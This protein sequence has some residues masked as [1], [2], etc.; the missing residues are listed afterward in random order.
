MNKKNKDK[1]TLLYNITNVYLSLLSSGNTKKI[2]NLV[3]SSK[4]C[5]YSGY[6]LK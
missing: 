2:D 3:I 1:Y 4:S 6:H 5:G